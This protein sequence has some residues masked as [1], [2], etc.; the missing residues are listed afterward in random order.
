MA[1]AK[2][3]HGDYATIVQAYRGRTFKFASRNFYSEFLAAVQVASD[4]TTY[5]GELELNRPYRTQQVVLDGY[6][7]LKA[8]CAHFKVDQK[9]IKALNP[10]LRSPVFHGQKY[11]PKGYALRLPASVDVSRAI[12]QKI[13]HSK[14]KPSYFYTV[15]RGDTAGKIARIH[16]VRLSDLILANNLNRRATIYPKQ[17]LRIPHKGRKKGTTKPAPTTL[18][19]RSKP[20]APKPSSP[21]PSATSKSVPQVIY[22]QPVLA[23][24]IPLPSPSKRLASLR[25]RMDDHGDLPSNEVVTA[26]VGFTSFGEIDGLPTGL[27]QVE[28]E[29]TL[30]HFADWA[31]VRTQSIRRINDLRFGSPL[32]LHQKVQIPLNKVTAREFE[33]QR[34]EFHKRLQE[35]FFATYT[36]NATDPYRV[37]RGDNFWSLCRQKFDVPMWLLSNYNPE[38]DFADLR[39]NQKLLIPSVELRLTGDMESMEPEISLSH[40]ERRR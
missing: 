22:P 29:E 34:Y 2:K 5:F 13:F 17:T 15:Q 11:V 9:E 12:P 38:V 26:D 39:M 32:H 8:L 27:I 40:T 18:A 35:D 24:V 28:V 6:A 14:Q 37:R 31:R 23:S 7:G 20:A 16:G 25:Q 30:G 36:V 4:Y 21:A 10:A 33:E 1:R 19:A 3:A